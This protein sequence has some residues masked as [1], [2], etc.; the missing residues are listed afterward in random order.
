VEPS[1][2]EMLAGA[3]TFEGNCT[4]LIS[5]PKAR[6]LDPSGLGCPRAFFR[7]VALLLPIP[8]TRIVSRMCWAS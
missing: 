3:R 1:Y 4:F 8:K 5:W 6:G 2:M 7:T